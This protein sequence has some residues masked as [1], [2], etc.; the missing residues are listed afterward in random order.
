MIEQ[1]INRIELNKKL[2]F[3]SIEMYIFRNY[4]LMIY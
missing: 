2:S 1:E 4:K 3:I